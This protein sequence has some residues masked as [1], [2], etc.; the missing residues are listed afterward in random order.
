M[1]S[2]IGILK[3]SK[4]KENASM[5]IEFLLTS[6]TQ[7]LITNKL[8]EFPVIDIV[9]QNNQL[10]E[11]NSFQNLEPNQWL[12]LSKLQTKAV[13]LISKAGY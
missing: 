6:N 5:F 1:P 11:I 12:E 10:P 7:E 9:N 2:G 8:F 13:E 4:N 3:T